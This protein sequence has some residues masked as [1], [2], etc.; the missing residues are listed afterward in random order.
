MNT[1]S[2]LQSINVILQNIQHINLENFENNLENKIAADNSNDNI[3]IKQ[4][5]QNIIENNKEKNLIKALKLLKAKYDIK[6]NKYA[7]FNPDEDENISTLN[8]IDI[9][10]S[11][12][13]Y[14][15]NKLPIEDK[16]N[17]ITEVI[18][19]EKI[20][21]NLDNNECIHLQEL[22][23]NNEKY[24]KYDKHN[25]KLLGCKNLLYSLINNKKTYV[26]NINKDN[27]IH[28]LS[29]NMYKFY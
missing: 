15:W 8:D 14:T 17:I 5:K 12:K 6:Q 4:H 10:N 2:A 3:D 20:K 25:K 13:I 23:L 7:N 19:L 29:N 18:T 22:L 28:K 21:L 27:K 11:E 1:L 16:I 26:L 9:E 24:I